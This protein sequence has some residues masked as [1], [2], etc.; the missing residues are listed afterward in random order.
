LRTGF[1]G[2]TSDKSQADAP[3]EVNNI[4]VTMRHFITLRE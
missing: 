1:A 3:G 2:V 4:A